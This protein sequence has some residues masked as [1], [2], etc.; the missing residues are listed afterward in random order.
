MCW[1]FGYKGKIL[2]GCREKDASESKQ[3]TAVNSLKFP[4]VEKVGKALQDI[5]NACVKVNGK[6]GQKDVDGFMCQCISEECNADVLHSSG[7]SY[8]VSVVA[9]STIF[10]MFMSLTSFIFKIFM[11]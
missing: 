5:P 3:E 4:F 7:S 9:Q 11:F 8:K 1:T 2:K 6:G 10:C